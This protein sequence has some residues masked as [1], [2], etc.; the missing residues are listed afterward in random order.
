MSASTVAPAQHK[1]PSRKGKKAWRKNVDISEVQAGLEDA[2]EEVIFGGI[3]SEKPS[4]QLFVL[5]TTGSEDIKEKHFK[6]AKPLKADEIIAARTSAVAPLGGKKR[7]SLLA[8]DMPMKRS[9]P[10]TYIPHAEV[11]RLRASAADGESRKIIVQDGVNHDPWAVQPKIQDPR[12]DFLEEKQPIREPTTLKHTPVSLTASGKAV[13]AVK[14]PEAGKSYN[15]QFEDWQSVVEKAGEKEVAAERKRL[16]EAQEEAERM[17]KALA[18]AAKPDP[19][20]DDEY[21]SAWES[22]WEGIQSGKEEEDDSLTKKRPE[23][24]TQAERNKIKRRKEKE[25]AE[26][27]EREMKKREEQ[28]QKIREIAREVKRKEAERRAQVAIV[29]QDSSESEGEE[30][31]RR[32]KLGKAFLPEA[33]LEVVLADELQDSLRALRPEGNLLKDRYRNLLV[34]GKLEMRTRTQHKKPK[35]ERTEKWTYKDFKL[36]A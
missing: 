36:P 31:L 35:T 33:P 16:Q 22:E 6:H 4:E 3:I 17:E 9:K 10:N 18:E 14:K 23:R 20:S 2:R 7:K 13:A 30:V 28:Q 21:E 8:E 24:K 29:S 19:V 34:N 11:Q 27:H 1:Q 32:R 25:R 5:D 15:P 26:K 12:F